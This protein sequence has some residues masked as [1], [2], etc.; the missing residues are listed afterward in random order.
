MLIHKYTCIFSYSQPPLYTGDDNL[1]I[2]DEEEYMSNHANPGY[3][4][5][6]R[7]NK[8]DKPGYAK[9]QPRDN[10]NHGYTRPMSN[11]ANPGNVEE[12]RA[13]HGYVEEPRSNKRGK[14]GYAK[15]QP[16]DNGNPGYTRPITCDCKNLLLAL[17]SIVTLLFILFFLGLAIWYFICKFN[18][19][20]FLRQ[21]LMI[22]FN[23][24]NMEKFLK[25]TYL[26]VFVHPINNGLT[27]SADDTRKYFK[28]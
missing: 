3:V 19:F 11:H 9:Q 15:Q 2:Y 7:S 5:E 23:I 12:P 21:T 27:G 26:K 17:L 4:E 22:N 25:K 6:P 1:S 18:C 10:G 16:C 8:R 20:V 13:N 24:D 28:L 14:P